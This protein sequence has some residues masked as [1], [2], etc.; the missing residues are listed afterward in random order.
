MQSSGTN[1]YSLGVKSSEFHRKTNAFF[2]RIDVEH[3]HGDDVAD[4]KYLRRMLYEPVANLRYVYQSVLMHANVH[5]SAE[6]DDVPHGSGELHA[7]LKVAYVEH[8]RAE[9]GLGHFVARVASGL[10]EL[11]YY[12]VKRGQA[13]AELFGKA[14]CTQRLYSCGE[15]AE[16]RRLYL[17]VS[18]SRQPEQFLCR[19]VALGV[20]AGIIKRLAALGHAQKA[21]ALFKSLR[22]E[23][24]H[25]L[26]FR[27]GGKRA[28]ILAVSH[29]V[30]ANGRVES[31]YPQQQ[32]GRCRIKVGSYGVHTVLDDAVQRLAEPF[33]RHI[34]LIL[35]YAYGLRLYLD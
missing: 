8:I 23:L 12:V 6:V 19:G 3:P 29:Y 7:L 10:C 11:L 14:L 2:R 21:R 18:L 32:S 9:H 25:L 4:R 35:T 15:V 22:P 1:I 5:E 27:A 16:F 28:V 26:Q 34:V 30:F 33:L 13:D 20:H 17:G 24:G 31:R